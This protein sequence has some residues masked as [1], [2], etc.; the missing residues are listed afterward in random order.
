MGF[1]GDVGGAGQSDDESEGSGMGTTLV[2]GE[3]VANMSDVPDLSS[4]ESVDG[5]ELSE[6]DNESRSP[7][8]QTGFKTKEGA[9]TSRIINHSKVDFGKSE[10]DD[11]KAT[12]HDGPAGSD[13]YRGSGTTS[14]CEDYYRGRVLCEGYGCLI[15]QRLIQSFET[16]PPPKTF[17]ADDKTD[18]TPAKT[19]LTKHETAACHQLVW[20]LVFLTPVIAFVPTANHLQITEHF[21]F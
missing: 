15:C 10:A 17:I 13:G 21:P 9:F 16:P 3:D 8:E 7:W 1:G 6:T 20:L 5:K 2:L 19:S 11:K 18:K 14:L 4:E 12:D